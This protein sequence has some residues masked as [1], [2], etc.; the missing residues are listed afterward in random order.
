MA[1]LPTTHVPRTAPNDGVIEAARAAL[2]DII[3]DAKDHVGE[4]TLTVRRESVVEA[5]SA[6][7]RAWNF[8]S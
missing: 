7:R 1:T 8:S 4:I 3:V 2:G 6:T 5:C